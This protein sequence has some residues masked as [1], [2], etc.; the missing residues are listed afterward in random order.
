MEVKL[1]VSTFF[2]VIGAPETTAEMRRWTIANVPKIVAASGDPWQREGL[3]PQA[4]EKAL[5]DARPLWG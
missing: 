5:R 3:R 1:P 2:N 4:L